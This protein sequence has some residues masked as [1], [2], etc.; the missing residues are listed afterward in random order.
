[1]KAMTSIKVGEPQPV[2]C[3]KCGDKYGYAYS[4][5]MTV[6]YQSEHYPDGDFEQGSYSDF[7][8]TINKGKTPYCSNCGCKLRF[9][10]DRVDSEEIITE[11]FFDKTR[12]P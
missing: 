7:S 10:L 1:M 2:P 6:N 5:Y 4:D 12:R 3:D 8:R 9:K 11:S